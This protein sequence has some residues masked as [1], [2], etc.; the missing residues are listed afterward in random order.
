MLILAILLLLIQEGKFAK[1]GIGRGMCFL[2]NEQRN[3]IDTN[4]SRF[5]GKDAIC[6][7]PPAC[8][9]QGSL[10]TI[11]HKLSGLA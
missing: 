1:N 2:L 7:I 6:S 4:I 9:F 3:I 8:N 11:F 10:S 5:C